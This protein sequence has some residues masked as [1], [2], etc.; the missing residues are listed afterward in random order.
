[1]KTHVVTFSYDILVPPNKSYFGKGPEGTA[2]FFDA[3]RQAD[4]AVAD[5]GNVEIVE[6]HDTLY[7]LPKLSDAWYDAPLFVRRVTYKSECS[8]KR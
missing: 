8:K 2:R 7:I 4:K 1:M 3:L 5:L 6:V